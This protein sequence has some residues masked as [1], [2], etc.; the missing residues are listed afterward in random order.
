MTKKSV[1]PPPQSQSV[2]AR[3]TGDRAQ[4]V[5]DL[6]ER[7][8]SAIVVGNEKTRLTGGRTAEAIHPHIED[9]VLA[10]GA[11]MESAAFEPQSGSAPRIIDVGTG[12][13]FPGLVWAILWPEAEVTL[14]DATKK[15]TDFLQAAV[16]DLGLENVKVECARSESVARNKTSR[17]S[18]DIAV[19]RALA[20]VDVGAEWMAP[21]VRPGGNLAFVKGSEVEDEIA[22]ARRACHVL[23]V[24]PEPHRRD[25]VRSDGKHSALLVYVKKHSTSSRFPRSEGKASRQPLGRGKG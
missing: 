22:S 24:E 18:W 8:V 4:S 19:A 5:F 14:L 25:Y 21:L 20:A 12:A 9:A 3:M 2:V 10:A 13:G 23:G 17:E 6:L 11:L 1:A 7:Y 15:K 16:N